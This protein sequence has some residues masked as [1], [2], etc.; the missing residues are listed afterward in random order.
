MNDDC[1]VKFVADCDVEI[2]DTSDML[3]TC[4]LPL[5]AGTCPAPLSTPTPT[6]TPSSAP[7]PPQ[8]APA[9]APPG[10]LQRIEVKGRQ[11]MVDG[12]PLHL[13]GVA[14]NPIKK[15]GSPPSGLNFAE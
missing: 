15:G 6:T 2:K 14:W 13:K 7:S 5:S 1:S 8:P 11:L 4:Q 10:D 9:P 3:C 12:K